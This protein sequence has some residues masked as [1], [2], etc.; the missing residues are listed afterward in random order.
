MLSLSDIIQPE[1]TIVV[2]DYIKQSLAQ[3]KQLEYLA[4]AAQEIA[5]SLET[6]DNLDRKKT[7]DSLDKLLNW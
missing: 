2:Y 1:S 4:S 3:Q 6:A 5:E 7:G